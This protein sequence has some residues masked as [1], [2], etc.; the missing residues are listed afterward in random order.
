[1]KCGK[2]IADQFENITE[3]EVDE[4]ILGFGM[5]DSSKVRDVF[6]WTKEN[7]KNNTKARARA[8]KHIKKTYQKIQNAIFGE[9][10][11]LSYDN[12]LA[13]MVGNLWKGVQ[14]K[15]FK[16]LFAHNRNADSTASRMNARK[17]LRFGRMLNEWQKRTGLGP[18]DFDKLTK[19]VDFGLDLIREM[20][21]KGSTKNILAQKL[22]DIIK[23]FKKIQVGEAN[24]FGAGM[25]VLEDHLITQW[26]NPVKMLG[27]VP[28]KQGRLLAEAEWI[29]TI[30]PLLDEKKMKRPITTEY[31]SQVY[32]A[33]TK[34]KTEFELHHTLSNKSL[35]ERMSST[36]ELHFKDADSWMRYNAKYGHPD[37]IGS[38]FKGMDVFDERLALMEDWGPDPEGMFQEMYKKMGPNLSTKQKIRLQ[39]A[40]RQISG[41]ATIVGNPALSQ[42]V[43]AIQAFQIITKL[44]KAVI[45]AFSDIAIGNAVLDTHGKGFLGSYG[46]TFKILKQR[47]SQSDKARQAELMHVTHQLGIGFDS[48]ISSAVNRWADIGMNPGFMSTAADS[49]FKINGLNAWTDL[50]REAFSKVASNNFA[51]KLK[52]SWKG[53]DET[54]EGKLFK[55][56]L[57]EYNISEKEWNQ[58]RDSNST[59]NLKD[60]LKDDADYKN[61]DLSSDE[62]ITADH[63]LS[64]TQNKEL[65]D[66]IG[67]FFVFESRNFVPEAGASSRANMMLMSNKGTAFGTFLQLFWTFRS[68][69]MKMATD[70]YPRIGTLPVHKLALHGF[71]P[72]V[73]LG[74]ASLATKKLIQGKEPPDVT[75][76]QTFIDSGVQSGILGV[77]GDFLL[78]SMNKMDSS[79]DESI[80][81]VNYELFK[82]MGEIMVGLVND[83][84]RAK[85]VLQKMRG[86]TPYVG[87]PLVE[88]VYNYAFYYPMLE[89]YNPGH[90]SRLEN[91]SATM[92]GS[93]Y[94]DWAKPTNFVP[95]GGYQ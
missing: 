20:F 7:W 42:M 52:S 54:L 72:M 93:P 13:K 73:A 46:S 28:T 6:T 10:D 83:D 58:L 74:Y 12:F 50:W 62:Y 3:Q 21:S 47:F 19:D 15:N 51:T 78:E 87:L 40:W 2:E 67:N 45:S 64:T 36:R 49:F 95:Y 70:I 80:L 88:H 81:G 25:Q 71:G 34:G 57:E 16:L 33:F 55:Q 35:A 27:S 84:L 89:T 30:R 75:D 8:K 90:L 66:K 24:S 53:L 38:I 26:H 17:N 9:G 69:T 14:I 61:V 94:M 85:D 79:L 11:D 41:E 39:S 29:D 63:V 48:L 5:E 23:E 56:R 44:P 18:A 31:L 91:F 86:N 65:S 82:D 32:R 1:M 43:N 76:P 59:F 92:A 77:A 37:P 22:S 60:L 68:L 4:L